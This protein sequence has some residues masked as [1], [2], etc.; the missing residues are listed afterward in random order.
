MEA[1]G[2]L[3]DGTTLLILGVVSFGVLLRT[4]HARNNIF[5]L[6]STRSRGGSIISVVLVNEV[7]VHLRG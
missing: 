1:R 6:L 2:P 4:M 3:T 5:W 7:G